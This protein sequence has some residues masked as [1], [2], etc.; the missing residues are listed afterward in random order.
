VCVVCY[1]AKDWLWVRRKDLCRV[2]EFVEGVRS[3]NLLLCYQHVMLM[4]Y[5][6]IYKASQQFMR[7]PF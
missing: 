4:E 6:H 3:T 5:L 7:M 2:H 1:A